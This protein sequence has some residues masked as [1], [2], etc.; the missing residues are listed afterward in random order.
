MQFFFAFI[1]YF[2]GTF[3]W[4]SMHAGTAGRNQPDR[5]RRLVMVT[6]ATPP[7]MRSAAAVRQ[8]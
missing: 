3:W 7:T 4:G 5:G 8:C 1:D 2:T 6:N